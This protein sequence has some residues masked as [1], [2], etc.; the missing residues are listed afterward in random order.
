MPFSGG[1]L[2]RDSNQQLTSPPPPSPNNSSTSQAAGLTPYRSSPSS[3]SVENGIWT[4]LETFKR[5]GG[6]SIDFCC[7]IRASH[8]PTAPASSGKD[9]PHRL[10]NCQNGRKQ[11]RSVKRSK[12][13]RAAREQLRHSPPP[14]SSPTTAAP[15]AVT[16]AAVNEPALGTRKYTAARSLAEVAAQPAK[17]MAID[18]PVATAKT[19]SAVLRGRKATGR[20]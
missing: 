6:I 13:W 15:P 8:H 17:K 18:T 20:Y 14:S 12:E 2:N 11:D 9:A 4:M 3:R 19:A 5:Q 7:R 16:P 1:I 10:D